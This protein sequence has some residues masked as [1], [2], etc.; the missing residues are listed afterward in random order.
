M[1]A[2][3]LHDKIY[4]LRLQCIPGKFKP[5]AVSCGANKAA[6][7]TAVNSRLAKGIPAS[8]AIWDSS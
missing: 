2:T 8:G 3:H 7:R 1:L 5:P 4:D 6:N